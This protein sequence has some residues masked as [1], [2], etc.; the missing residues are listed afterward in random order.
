MTI[1]GTGILKG[2]FVTAVN[3]LRKVDTIQY[4]SRRVGISGVIKSGRYKNILEFIKNDFK[5]FL[6][7]MVAQYIILVDIPQS[8]RFRGNEFTWYEERCT[9]CAACAKYCP[10]GIIE[11]VTHPGGIDTEVGESYAIDVFNIDIGRCMFCGFC[12]EACPYDALH[13]GTK[14]ERA[15]LDRASLLIEKQELVAAVK[16]PSSWFRPQLEE[17]KFDPFKETL[18]EHKKAGRHEKPNAKTIANRW[19]NRK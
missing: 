13:M 19:V 1:I 11:I 6:L 7:A 2:M 12:V 5:G 3:F 15:K 4:P 8:S 16:T 9:G 18:M 17:I 14:F 10:L